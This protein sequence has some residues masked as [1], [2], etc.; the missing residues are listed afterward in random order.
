MNDWQIECFITVAETL[1]FRK[2][3]SVLHV[4]QPALT[5]QVRALENT[6][7]TQLF[8]RDTTHVS[9][10]EDGKR[11]YDRALEL[12]RLITSAKDMF[13]SKTHIVF[14]YLYGY[15]LAQVVPQF[16][17]AC[18]DAILQLL[19]LKMW[20][21]TE[22]VL[23][24]PDNIVLGRA[25]EMAEVPGIAF[26]PLFDAQEYVVVSAESPF[27]SWEKI[28]HDD[29]R[30]QTIIRSGRSL[31]SRNI[32]AA[33]ERNEQRLRDCA[34][35]GCDNLSEAIAMVKN[36]CGVAFFLLPEDI[37]MQGIV[38]IP[39]VDPFRD[40]VGVGYLQ[41]YESEEMRTLATILTSVYG[42]NGIPR[43]LC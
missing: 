22:P 14:N 7:G 25:S 36:D 37:D 13:R 43:R 27:A 33:G 24:R 6:L 41:R 1:N 32:S 23:Q 42:P 18:P 38:R 5:K 29:L 39:V 34:F 28:T 16:R 40:Q 17:E 21:N 3:A 10:T 4:S 31:A 19:R 30:G 12:H 11:F 20:G 9:L 8:D 15:G 2:A 35:I 26:T